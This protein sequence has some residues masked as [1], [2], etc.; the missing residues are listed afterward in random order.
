MDG[1][2]L[3]PLLTWM[4][5]RPLLGG[6]GRDDGQTQAG[7]GVAGRVGLEPLQGKARQGVSGLLSSR[8]RGG[9]GHGS[10]APETWRSR[11]ALDTGSSTRRVPPAA[12]WDTWSDAWDKGGAL[13]S[14]PGSSDPPQ[15]RFRWGR[16]PLCS[17]V[18][19]SRTLCFWE[20]ATRTQALWRPSWSRLN[21]PSLPARLRQE[22][23]RASFHAAGRAGVS[24]GS[25]SA[26]FCKLTVAPSVLAASFRPGP[27]LGKGPRAARPGAYVCSVGAGG[28]LS[29][30]LGGRGHLSS[31]PI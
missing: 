23:A 30:P 24:A 16:P 10:T 27:C 28:C 17:P 4:K 22:G 15:G 31:A 6:P 8:A 26:D 20:T 25:G 18:R 29:G 12:L 5:L 19:L 21:F 14:L 13:T 9:A 1:D 11:P 7:R 3:L 2:L